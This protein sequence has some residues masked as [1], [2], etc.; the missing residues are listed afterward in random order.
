MSTWIPVNLILGPRT[1][2]WSN[3]Q[4]RGVETHLVE[5]NAIETIENRGEREFKKPKM[6]KEQ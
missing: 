3:I 1:L 2:Q 5:L 6:L 4:S